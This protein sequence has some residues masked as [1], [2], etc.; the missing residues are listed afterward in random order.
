M[1]ILHGCS[2]TYP[3][4]KNKYIENNK[5]IKFKET[6]VCYVDDLKLTIQNTSYSS[7]TKEEAYEAFLIGSQKRNIDPKKCTKIDPDSQ[8]I[9]RSIFT[10][11]KR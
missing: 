4:T 10:L 11:I 9:V 3:V 6:Y 5:K 1:F 7:L 2:N 8:W